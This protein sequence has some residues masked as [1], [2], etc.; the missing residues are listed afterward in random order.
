MI[1]AFTLMNN[2]LIYV[3]LHSPDA[4]IPLRLNAFATLLHTVSS[5]SH[6]MAK[7]GLRQLDGNAP[8]DITGELLTKVS[9]LSS[10]CN[11]A[12]HITISGCGL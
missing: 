9:T 1:L 8:W 2:T 4:L 6:H 7:A 10:S 12:S 3:S 5:A 11:E